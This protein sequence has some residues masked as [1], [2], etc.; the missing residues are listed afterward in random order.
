MR[1][2]LL[3]FAT[4]AVLSFAPL[5]LAQQ[6]PNFSKPPTE[7]FLRQ[8]DTEQL[9]ILRTA[10][11]SCGRVGARRV[12]RDPCVI[13]R[14]DEG[15]NQAGNADLQAFHNRLVPRDR[16]DETRSSVVW[17]NWATGN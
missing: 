10:L 14:T 2:S 12:D 17:R 15:V 16:Y 11:R 4:I 6:N 8:L 1:T 9:E 5:A 13:L 7:D 3:L